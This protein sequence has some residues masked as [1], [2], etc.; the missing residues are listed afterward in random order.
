MKSLL[1]E[2]EKEEIGRAVAE[3][4]K[5][6]SGE[7][8][9]YLVQQSGSYEKAIWRGATLMAFA[10]IC[11]VLLVL[12]FYGGWGF[13]WIHSGWGTALIVLCA[14]CLGA[15]LSAIWPAL[16]RILA[17]ETIMTS[18]V[19]LRAIQA[20]VDEEVFNTRDRTGILLFV[21]IFERRI[22]VMGDAGINKQVLPEDWANVVT[23]VRNGILSNKLAEGLVEAIALCGGL[24]EKSGVSIRPDDTNEL[25]D[26]IRIRKEPS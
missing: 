15:L 13:A 6:T 2:N 12:Q 19:H 17:G 1:T 5:R 11:F 7:I 20:F 22:E 14:G 26:S 18:M 8:V 24:L 23:S 9:P 16:K 4:E 21:S 25:P 10:A 3:A